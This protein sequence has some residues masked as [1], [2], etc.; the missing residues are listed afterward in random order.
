MR[1]SRNLLTLAAFAALPLSA[2]AQQCS[3]TVVTVTVTVEPTAQAAETTLTASSV[4]SQLPTEVAGSSELS[5]TAA[6]SSV[7]VRPTLTTTITSKTTVTVTPYGAASGTPAGSVCSKITD[8][9]AISAYLSSSTPPAVYTPAPAT[10][11]GLQLSDLVLVTQQAAHSSSTSVEAYS[12]PA[13]SSTSAAPASATSSPPDSSSGA[14][15]ALDGTA[16][17]GEATFYGGNTD[18]GMCSFAGYTIPSGVFGTALSSSNWANAGNCGAC[19]SVTGPSGEKI[20]AMI[21]DQCPGCG[22][23]HLDLFENAFT[24][25]AAASVGVIPVS[26]ELVECGITTP[27]SI[28]NKSGTSAYWFSM[29]VVNSNVPVEKLEVST[30]GGS[31][32]TAT[33]RQDYNYFQYSAGF[34]SAAVS[35]KVTSSTGKSIVIDNVIA[36]SEQSFEASSNF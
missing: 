16:H 30:D 29:Q 36:G 13:V 1:Q 20:T 8:S 21:V 17:S 32:W 2:I 3:N 26:W 25:L 15:T 18:G 4:E 5:P 6:S 33:E 28:R 34:G 11:S 9:A 31:S 27:I 7:C 35:V 19:V 12:T 14:G 22:D 23:N 10:S 24:N